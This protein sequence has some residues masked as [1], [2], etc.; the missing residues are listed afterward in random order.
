[1]AGEVPMLLWGKLAMKELLVTILLLLALNSGVAGGGA[2]RELA[3]SEIGLQLAFVPP[4][5]KSSPDRVLVSVTNESLRSGGFRLPSPFV[6][7]DPAGFAPYPPHLALRVKE[8]KTGREEVFVFTN[9]RKP[10][11]PGE[12]VSLKPE[13]VRTLEYPLMLFYRWGPCNP[14]D[15]N[16]QECF[17]PGVTELEVRAEVF[18]VEK[19]GRRRILSDPQKLRCSFPEGLFQPTSMD[20]GITRK[21]DENSGRASKPEAMP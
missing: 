12:L 3:F 8:P 5:G 17:K 18:V 9:L 21:S 1:M 16:F 14:M 20:N 13:Q 6:A 11:G 15:G 4:N 7:E 19:R 10:N 2:Q